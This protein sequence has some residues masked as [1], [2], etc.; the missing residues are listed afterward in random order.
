MVVVDVGVPIVA[1][2]ESFVVVASCFSFSHSE[3]VV[4]LI[5]VVLTVFTVGIDAIV[6]APFTKV[7]WLS[8]QR[9]LSQANEHP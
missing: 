2:V 3:L 6:K 1:V 9:V 8:W 4:D 7:F 5:A